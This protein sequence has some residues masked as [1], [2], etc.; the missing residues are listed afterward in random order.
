MRSGGKGKL[1]REPVTV[2]GKA[3]FLVHGGLVERFEGLSVLGT[4]AR[5]EAVEE[6]NGSYGMGLVEGN[7]LGI[8]HERRISR[9]SG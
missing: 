5:N 6:W 3:M 8:D 1:P 4:R 7:A 9:F 2:A